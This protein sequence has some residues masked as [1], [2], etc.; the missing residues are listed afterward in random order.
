MNLSTRTLIGAIA[1]AAVIGLG[2]EWQVAVVIGILV[3]AFA[4]AG[5]TADKAVFI[6]DM[7]SGQMKIQPHDRATEEYLNKRRKDDNGG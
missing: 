4:P 3:T 7:E 2:V 5:S 1:T 6:M